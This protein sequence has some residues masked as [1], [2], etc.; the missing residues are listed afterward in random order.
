M[1]KNIAEA[2][3]DK[4]EVLEKGLVL[5]SSVRSGKE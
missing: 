5:I 1:K 2:L 3:N 4:G